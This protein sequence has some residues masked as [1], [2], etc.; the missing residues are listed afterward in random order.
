MFLSGPFFRR[1]GDGRRGPADKRGARSC[2]R[3][4]A[5]RL[6][7][8]SIAL[9]AS[10]AAQAHAILVESRPAIGAAVAHGDTRIVLR[11]NCR[12]D[13]ARSRLVLQDAARKQTTVVTI[14]PGSPA[15]SIAART[16]LQAGH[17]TLRWQV[18]AVDGHIS[19][20]D[21]AFTVTD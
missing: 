15:D 11:F 6:S 19:R 21:V 17:Y 16:R 5:R 9:F 14:D 20:G 13:A 8:L 4:I 3:G 10:A 2:H 7:I 12:I 18:L 1:R